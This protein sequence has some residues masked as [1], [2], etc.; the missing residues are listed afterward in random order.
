MGGKLSGYTKSKNGVAV[1]RLDLTD[2]VESWQGV[3]RFLNTSSLFLD[4][5]PKACIWQCKKVDHAT[6]F[7]QTAVHR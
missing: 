7:A 6:H 3:L 4:Q 5:V 2:V 1:L